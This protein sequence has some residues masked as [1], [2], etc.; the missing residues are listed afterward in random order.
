MRTEL[1]EV[2]L[3]NSIRHDLMKP[4]SSEFLQKHVYYHIRSRLFV[5]RKSQNFKFFII[6]P[7]VYLSTNYTVTIIKKIFIYEVIS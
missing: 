2:D 3:D 5:I 1:S 4:C 6:M 7:L